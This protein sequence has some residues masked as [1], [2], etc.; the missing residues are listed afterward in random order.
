MNNISPYWRI[1]WTK[2]MVLFKNE[3]LFKKIKDEEEGEADEIIQK[4]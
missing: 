2:I 4:N 3:R 1:I